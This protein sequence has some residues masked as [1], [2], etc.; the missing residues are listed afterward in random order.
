MN[1][2]TNLIG[3]RTQQGAILRNLQ[4]QAGIPDDLPDVLKPTPS[5]A[6]LKPQTDLL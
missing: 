5:R 4:S 3:F 1:Q 6:L 2:G